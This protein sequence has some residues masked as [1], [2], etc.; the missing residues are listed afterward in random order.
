MDSELDSGREP[1]GRSDGQGV[2][3]GS[4]LYWDLG[5]VPGGDGQ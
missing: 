2:G 1:A 5:Q 4:S 3:G